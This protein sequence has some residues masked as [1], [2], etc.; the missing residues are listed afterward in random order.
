MPHQ[1]AVFIPHPIW[2]KSA[3]QVRANIEGNDPVTGK[4]FMQSVVAGLTKP[5]SADEKKSG[6]I[7]GSAGPRTIGP[8][9]E[10]NLHQYYLDNG[11]T[12]YLP[13]VLPTEERVAEMLQGTSR[14]PDE[15]VG[16]M[17]PALNAYPP[18]SY[19]VE[20]VAVNA[21]MAGA[22]PEYFPVILALAASGSSSLSSSTN[23][24]ARMVVINGPI[25]NKIGL[26]YG[27][28]AM[29]PFSHA[30][31]TIGRAWTLLSKNLGHGGIAGETYLGALG[32]PT[33]YNNIIIAENEEENPWQPFHVDKG[34]KAE[35]STV[36]IFMGYG[37]FSA[38]GTVAGRISSD[39]KFDQ[40]LK[41]V[42]STLNSMFGG[43][44]VLDPTVAQN[45]YDHGYD[46]KEKL[47]DYIMQKGEGERP[48]F[49]RPSD[50][51]LVVTG[52]RTNLYYNYGPMRYGKTTSIDEWM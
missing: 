10:A 20:Q 6:L 30:N 28:G 50:V 25:R 17:S 23:S 51:S 32:N 35:E 1:R 3:E 41:G 37:I 40:Q 34:F 44:A 31:A 11:F 27:I 49:R 48:Q 33:S 18:W 15:I 19:T 5:L 12:D 24:F 16:K 21:V 7:K 39:P 36:S 14:K 8:D 13:I 42:F 29:G 26:N 52:G 47:I 4:P 9:T 46:T 45:I 38:Q 2:G 22:S 43:F